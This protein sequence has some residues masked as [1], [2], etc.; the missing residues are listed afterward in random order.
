[1]GAFGELLIEHF[2]GDLKKYRGQYEPSNE[3]NKNNE[4][5]EKQE[6]DIELMDARKHLTSL[7]NRLIYYPNE[8]KYYTE[9][10]IKDGLKNS[11]FSKRV[12]NIIWDE[13]SDFKN[14]YS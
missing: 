3:D 2:G 8:I 12:Q 1:M 11:K 10:I 5:V 7:E 14:K 6:V 4:E 13:F 9:D